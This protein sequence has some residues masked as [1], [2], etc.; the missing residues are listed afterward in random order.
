LAFEQV[1]YLVPRLRD[2]WWP[3]T[4][5]P[6]DGAFVESLVVL[7]EVDLLGETFNCPMALLTS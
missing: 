5:L 4:N 6:L 3:G 1:N 7:D 2:L